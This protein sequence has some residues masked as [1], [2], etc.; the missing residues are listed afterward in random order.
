MRYCLSSPRIWDVC[1]PTATLKEEQERGKWIRVDK[2]LNKGIGMTFNYLYI[3]RLQPNS[4]VPV[5]TKVTMVDSTE[6]TGDAEDKDPTV[7]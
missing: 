2:D 5:V 6:L 7:G 3:R 4:K 1:S